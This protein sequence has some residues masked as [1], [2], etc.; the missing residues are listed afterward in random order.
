MV[1]RSADGSH[2]GQGTVIAPP[3]R[4]VAA[5]EAE[6]PRSEDDLDPQEGGPAVCPRRRRRTDDGR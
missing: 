2:M 6:H 1:L 5:G 4:R 3:W